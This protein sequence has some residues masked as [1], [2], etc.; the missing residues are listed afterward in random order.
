MAAHASANVLN[1]N[2]MDIEYASLSGSNTLFMPSNYKIGAL[3][4]SRPA[5][6]QHVLTAANYYTA[7]IA[8]RRHFE[9]DA[10]AAFI[11]ATSELNDRRTLRAGLRWEETLTRSRE[12]DAL[13]ASLPQKTQVWFLLWNLLGVGA[14]VLYGR[15]R[16]SRP[17]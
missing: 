1:F 2:D 15:R 3:F 7:Y 10:N 13:L 12:V 8:N 9:E 17:E 11:M 16:S 6:F 14:Y 5:L 4:Q